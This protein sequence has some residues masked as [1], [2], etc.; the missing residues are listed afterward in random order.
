MPASKNLPAVLFSLV[1]LSGCAFSDYTNYIRGTTVDAT[2]SG[3]SGP[4]DA[5]VNADH[6]Y[7]LAA[8]VMLA[9]TIVA[10]SAL[11]LPQAEGI[12]TITYRSG[13]ASYGSGYA[14]TDGLGVNGYE[15]IDGYFPGQYVDESESPVYVLALLGVFADGDGVI[16][17]TPF[18]I[19]N[20]PRTVKVP[21]GAER[22]QIGFNDHQYVD[23]TGSIVVRIGA[24]P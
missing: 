7:G 14:S 8:N 24:V 17:G 6:P 20:G 11:N 3:Q 18:K 1:M 10:L 15:A 19:G 21:Q 16:V 13:S 9:P 5:T 12:L 23:N 2:V 22:L 4:W